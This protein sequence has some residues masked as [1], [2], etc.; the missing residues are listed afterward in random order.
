MWAIGG[1]EL[2]NDIVLYEL[3][4]SSQFIYDLFTCE[5]L[6]SW[7]ISHGK[8]LARLFYDCSGKKSVLAV[9]PA[10]FWL[11]LFC[12]QIFGFGCSAKKISSHVTVLHM[13]KSHTTVLSGTWS[14]RINS[15]M[16]ISAAPEKLLSWQYI[17]PQELSR[18]SRYIICELY[19]QDTRTPGH[20]IM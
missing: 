13:I 20:H 5:L 16:T 11:W 6:S 2:S 4:T 17:V 1:G 19:Y 18:K 3:F 8:I 10:N 15:H 7:Q 14:Y 12:R 9:L